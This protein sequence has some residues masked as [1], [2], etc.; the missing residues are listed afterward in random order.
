MAGFRPLSRGWDLFRPIDVL[1]AL[2]S[3]TSAIP[4]VSTGAAAA[5][6]TLFITLRR[7][8]VGRTLSVRLDEGDIT[9]T[10][11]EFDSRLELRGLAVGQLDNVRLVATDLHWGDGNRIDR[12]VVTLHNVHLRPSTPP[13]VVA[14]PVDMS[15]ELPASAL[16]ELFRSSMPRLTGEVGA[17]AVARLR[18]ARRPA[19]GALEVD[20]HLDG[21]TLWLKPRGLALRRRRWPIPAWVPAYPVRLPELPRGLRLTGVDCAPGSLRLT[22][23][24]PEWRM[25]MPRAGLEEILN[26]LNS[27]GR[28]LNLT[29]TLRAR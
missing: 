15:L 14:A 1:A 3:S 19:L 7:L 17:D 21:S 22:G 24:L 2:W 26:Q 6:R 23:T 13:V 29:R 11:T 25:D 16:D 4:P 5:Y 8:V 12:A 18:W 20:T 28:T 10:V 9:L 27:V